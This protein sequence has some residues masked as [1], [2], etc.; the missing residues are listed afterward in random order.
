MSCP[1]CGRRLDPG[2]DAKTDADR[3]RTLVY[4]SDPFGTCPF[5]EVGNPGEGI[6]VVT[7]DDELYRLLP[8]FVISTA[9]KF[10]QLPWKGPLH[11]LFG[12]VTHR[13]TRHGYRS[14][15]LD[16]VGEREE[17]NKYNRTASLPAAETVEC[18]P[19]RPPD[20]II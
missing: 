3:W 18:P 5:T 14:T 20:L 2:R 8:A 19:L 1:W 12:R 16:K 10:A 17:R 9:D 6:P 4:C 11:L 15:D 13:C 7:V